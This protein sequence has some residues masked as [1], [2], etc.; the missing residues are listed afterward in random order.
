MRSWCDFG[1]MRLMYDC[2]DLVLLQFR[3]IN[4]DL[5]THL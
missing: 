4:Q 2:T 3:Q 1:A 5:L